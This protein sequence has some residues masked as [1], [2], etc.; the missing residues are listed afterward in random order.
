[1]TSPPNP[2]TVP[3]R[4]GLAEVDPSLQHPVLQRLQTA[5]SVGQSVRRGALWATGSRVLSQVVQVAGVVV[6][7]RVLTPDDYG[8][9]AVVLPITAF[10]GIFSSLGLGSAVVHHRHVTEKLLSTVFWL[11][12]ATGVAL[13][14]LLC[15]L[16]V[17]V[18]VVFR[19]PVLV[20]LLSLASLTI[21]LNLTV[22]PVTLLERTLRFKQ[23]ALLDLSSTVLGLVVL[24][25][26]AL[27]GAGPFA[28]VLG[29]LAHTL[30]ATI[31][32]WAMVR[33]VPRAAPDR[34]TARE[35]WSFSRGIVGF[36]AVVFWSRNADNLALARVV[37]QAE[38]GLYTRAYALMTLPVQ[39][40]QL[41]MGRVLFPALA[42]L[43]DDPQR[44]GQ[45]WLR[46]LV[47]AAAVTAPLT[48]GMAVTA[49]ALV[50][51]ALGQRWVE[52]APLLTILAVSAL[53]QIL[54]APV[55]GLMRA[56]GGTDVLFKLG[57]VV[58]GMTLLS[59]L[60]G[61]PWGTTGVAL[62]L[63]VKFHVEV[64]VMLGPCLQ[65]TRLR[66][67]DLGRAMRGVWLSCVLLAAAALLVRALLPSAV[68]PWK[69]LL[70]QVAAGGATYVLALLLLDRAPLRLLAGVLRRQSPASPA[71]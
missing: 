9:A 37:S 68:E 30:N 8:T 43:R 28:L 61:L 51:V 47:V 17:P 54:T 2:A 22:V 60:V 58:T 59:I 44:L 69:V 45:A 63:A 16:A 66:W 33:W 34:A 13:A 25:A 26:A 7:A 70:A 1:M 64:Y 21:A 15:A 11:N 57:L 67:S 18:S 71:G 20:P 14:G 32:S 39:Q 53:P 29:P 36:S 41:L 3:G 4:P 12:T 27:A 24:V 42:R 38:L 50:E 48:Y 49:P 5:S 19:D 55:G 35:V 56:T 31:G 62:A 46:A 23:I 40:M 6:T 65:R 10:A 52:M